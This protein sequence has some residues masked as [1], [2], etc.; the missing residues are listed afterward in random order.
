MKKQRPDEV[1]PEVSSMF[2]I[3]IP[4]WTIGDGFAGFCVNGHL[5]SLANCGRRVMSEWLMTDEKNKQSFFSFCSL[6]MHRSAIFG[7]VLQLTMDILTPAAVFF[8]KKKTTQ[9]TPPFLLQNSKVAALFN[10]VQCWHFLTYPSANEESLNFKMIYF[11]FTYIAHTYAGE[12]KPGKTMLI[13]HFGGRLKQSQY[14]GAY[15]Q[16][17]AFH[18]VAF[19]ACC[20]LLLCLC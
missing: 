9:K 19:T 7:Q 4:K 1:T 13:C 8:K 18:Y 10:L 6:L 5:P 2:S 20:S 17:A 14:D 3:W 15:Q 12:E 11:L 16:A